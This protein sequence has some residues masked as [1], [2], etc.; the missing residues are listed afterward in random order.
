MRNG[1]AWPNEDSVVAPV[2]ADKDAVDLVGL[3]FPEAVVDAD[4]NFRVI[5]VNR[6]SM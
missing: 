4:D 6:F 2:G 5:A 3:E 1:T